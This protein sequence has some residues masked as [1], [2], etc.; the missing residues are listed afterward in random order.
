MRNKVDVVAC[1]NMDR[2]TGVHWHLYDAALG[3]M[4]MAKAFAG[5]TAS[6]TGHYQRSIYFKG[7]RG[8]GRPAHAEF[9]S[10]DFKAWW[11]EFGAN[12]SKKRSKTGKI[13]GRPTHFVARHVMQRAAEAI[14]LRFIRDHG[15]RRPAR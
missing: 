13:I 6:R 10:T 11:I 3:G 1:K 7:T 8:G 15:T 9:G 4:L 2:L 12:P 14:G 5:A